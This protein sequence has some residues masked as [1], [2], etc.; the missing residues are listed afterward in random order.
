MGKLE[1]LHWYGILM[2]GAYGDNDKEAPSYFDVV[3][4]LKWNAY[5][6]VKGMDMHEARIT[7]FEGAHQMLGERGFTD[8]HPDKEKID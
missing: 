7:F 1:A 6:D 5:E 4:R 3:E 2:Q 8:E